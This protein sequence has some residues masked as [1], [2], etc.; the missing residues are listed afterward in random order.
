MSSLSKAKLERVIIMIMLLLE[1][2]FS[3]FKIEVLDQGAF[4]DLEMQKTEYLT[5]YLKIRSIF[6]ILRNVQRITYPFDVIL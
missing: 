1:S 6:A 4:G 3:R 5:I 2:L